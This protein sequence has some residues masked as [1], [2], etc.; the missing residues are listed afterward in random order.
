MT[1]DAKWYFDDGVPGVGE[2]PS[3]LEPKDTSLAQPA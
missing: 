3:Y 1:D 2:R